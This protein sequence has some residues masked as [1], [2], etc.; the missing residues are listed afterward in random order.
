MKKQ[1]LYMIAEMVLGV[2][3]ASLIAAILTSI[4]IPN[5]INT[6]LT[7]PEYQDYQHQ[8]VLLETLNI[9]PVFLAV[10][11][12]LISTGGFLLFLNILN[13]SINF[14]NL[15]TRKAVGKILVIVLAVLFWCAFFGFLMDVMSGIGWQVLLSSMA[16]GVIWLIA[17]ETGWGGDLTSWKY[18]NKGSGPGIKGT[19][20]MG[21]LWGST[22]PLYG[23]PFNYAGGKY[24]ILISEV[25]DG[26]SETSFTGFLLLF[27]GMTFILSFSFGIL[28]GLIF[29]LAP[30]RINLHDRKGLLLAP[31]ILLLSLLIISGGGYLYAL[32]NYDLDAGSLAEAAGLEAAAPAVMTLVNLTPDVAEG[33]PIA[34]AWPLESEVMGIAYSG[35]TN[36]SESN[37]LILENFL[38]QKQGRTVYQYSAMSALDRGYFMLLDAGKA[39]KWLDINSR[40]SVLPRMIQLHRLRY[41]PVTPE[42]RDLLFRYADESLWR[43]PGKAAFNLARAF[44]HFGMPD[45]SQRW[46][47]KATEEGVDTKDFKP[48]ED[49]H[50]TDGWIGG[51]I[52]V[53]GGPAPEIIVGLMYYRDSGDFISVT[54][55]QLALLASVHP[56]DKTMFMFPDLGSGGYRLIALL[57]ETID[58]ST[59]RVMGPAAPI[60][61]NRDNPGVDL[62]TILIK[63]EQVDL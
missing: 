12:F 39:E 15:R 2:L 63:V 20:L 60:V 16:M 38:E 13:P 56:D 61:L 23:I 54:R 28:V 19:L 50:L 48:S 27:A 29:P 44:D 47:E 14:K 32:H 21:A 31:G 22:L 51:K 8:K 46:F 26:S 1:I 4:A 62:G 34:Q 58:P 11:G 41:L 30:V 25:L 40:E 24:F 3:A 45:K 37:L 53:K 6:L 18:E 49:P 57:K 5:L 17:G 10:Y 43:I 36:V 35:T 7:W 55:L 59:I 42:N 9:N 52:A 33:E